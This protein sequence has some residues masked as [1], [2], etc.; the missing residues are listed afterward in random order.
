MK[1][2]YDGSQHTLAEVQLN[3]SNQI[4]RDLGDKPVNVLEAMFI[5][6]LSEE[7]GEVAG[8]Y[9]RRL[10]NFTADGARCT[11]E[12]FKEELGDVLWYL[13]AVA[14]MMNISLDDIWQYN[15]EKLEERYGTKK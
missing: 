1:V 2:I 4:D 13:A 9:K 10:R 7:A 8:L 6:G 5:L 11:K 15:V 14:H 3:I 12:K